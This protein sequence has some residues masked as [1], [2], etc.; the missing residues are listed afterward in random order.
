MLTF[1]VQIDVFNIFVGGNVHGVNRKLF[2][3]H[4][5]FMKE[6]KL[7]IE[8]DLNFLR[9]SQEGVCPLL[10]PME[11]IIFNYISEDFFLPS[12]TRVTIAVIRAIWLLC[13][14]RIIHFIRFLYFIIFE[15]YYFFNFHQHIASYCIWPQ[16]ITF[17]SVCVSEFRNT[18]GNSRMES[19]NKFILVPK[20]IKYIIL[21]L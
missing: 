4:H 13:G 1:L 20:C 15:W 7:P 5:T 16:I 21:S 8:I 18:Q 10:D 19:G 12:R 6:F 2:I 11:W 17:M 3:T 14:V 9:K